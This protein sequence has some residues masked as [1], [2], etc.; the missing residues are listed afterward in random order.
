M[1]ILFLLEDYNYFYT[2]EGENSLKNNKHI[3]YKKLLGLLLKRKYYQAD[4][5]ANAF[6]KLGHHAEII[7]PE[8]NPL[9]K[10]W[11]KE[12]NRRLFILWKVHKPIRSIKARILKKHRTSY[13]AIQFRTLKEQ[14]KTIKPDIIYFYSNIYITKKQLLTLKSLT[15]KVVLQWSTPLWRQFPHFPYQTFDAIITASPQLQE[16]FLARNI[17]TVYVQQSFDDTILELLEPKKDKPEKDLVFIGGFSIGH[18]YRFETLEFLL[19][20]GVN[21]DIYGTGKETLPKESLVYKRMKGPLYGIDMYNMYRRYK[22]ALHIHTTGYNNDGINWS[23]Y[24]GAKR[25]FEITGVGTLLLTSHQE[26]IKDLF[27][28]DDEVVTFHDFEDL[29]I[30][31]KHLINSPDRIKT[32]ALNGQKKVLHEHTFIQRAQQII[33]YLY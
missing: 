31:I 21:I 27:I 10:L 9:Q 12:N 14:V 7:V 25:I 19:K 29:L 24:A 1:K 22:M 28:L 8:A 5:M 2:R 4:S 20:E 11:L 15:K 26:N 3:K 16:Y 18:N 23:K 32:I 6:R 30:K 33:N 17:K 13:N